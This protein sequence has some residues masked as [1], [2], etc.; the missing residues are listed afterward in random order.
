MEG[1][2]IP[3]V[4]RGGE[5]A[6][7]TLELERA[8]AAFA[9]DFAMISEILNRE[10]VERDWCEDYDDVMTEINSR[11]VSGR[12]DGRPIELDLVVEGKVIFHFRRNMSIEGGDPNQNLADVEF[13]NRVAQ[14][15]AALGMGMLTRSAAGD[16][17][18]HVTN[19]MWQ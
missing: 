18:V 5:V 15:C 14:H 4:E 11:M 19:V 1:M 3:G 17:E 12:L 6:R 2:N 13:R 16:S 9:K 10:A 7:L 8:K